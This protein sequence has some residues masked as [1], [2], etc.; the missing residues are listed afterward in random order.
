MRINLFSDTNDNKNS[1]SSSL[2]EYCS[3]VFVYTGLET[4][5]PLSP[6]YATAAAPGTWSKLKSNWMPCFIVKRWE[7]KSTHGT[8]K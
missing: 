7:K 4:A 1:A 2:S 5:P 8:K 6:F 3:S